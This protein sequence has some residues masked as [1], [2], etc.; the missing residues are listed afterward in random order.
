[1]RCTRNSP[2]TRHRAAEVADSVAAVV[3]TEFAAGT[4]LVE[5][6]AERRQALGCYSPLV[7]RPCERG[8]L[9]EHATRVAR[10]RLLQRGTA[11][12]E[13]GVVDVDLQQQLMRVD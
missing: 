5:R 11:A 13:L 9:G 8:V 12:L 2:H 10:C 6:A 7:G 4:H 1:M 3:T